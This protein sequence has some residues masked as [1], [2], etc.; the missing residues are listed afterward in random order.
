MSLSLK[1]ARRTEQSL[2]GIAA[3]AIVGFVAMQL[4]LAGQT[5]LGATKTETLPV[6]QP[7]DGYLGG[8][9]YSGGFLGIKGLHNRDVISVVALGLLGL[10]AYSTISDARGKAGDGA[11]QALAKKK[12]LPIYDVLKSMPDDFSKLVAL[13]VAG[14][15]V[16]FLRDERPFTFF[17]PTNTALPSQGAVPP[18]A[19]LAA[20]VQRHALAGRYT[21]SDLLALKDGSTLMML[22]GD[23]V[24]IGNK[25]GVLTI[26]NVRITQSDLEASN[27]W[28]HPLEGVL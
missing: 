26:N 12:T 24:T 21:I 16:A 9:I 13:V 27:G 3:L 28:I 6:V 2:R 11:T 19:S 4:P 22:S 20:L 15:Q 17:A 7:A 23:E 8:T 10:G 18:K 14:E 5:A 25:E 1:Q